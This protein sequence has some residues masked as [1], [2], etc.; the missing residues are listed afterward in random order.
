M[1]CSSWCTGM[2]P[3]S[4]SKQCTF[5]Y[6][7]PKDLEPFIWMDIFFPFESLK[8]TSHCPWEG[9]TINHLRRVKKGLQ[10]ADSKIGLNVWFDPS[11]GKQITGKNHFKL[12]LQAPRSLIVKP[13]PCFLKKEIYWE[14]YILSILPPAMLGEWFTIGLSA[15]LLSNIQI[16]MNLDLKPR[17]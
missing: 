12:F 8:V 15:N 16:L 6:V 5:G 1:L 9:T 11:P 3:L 14:R 17:C 10:M 2:L 13:L 4:N 7:N